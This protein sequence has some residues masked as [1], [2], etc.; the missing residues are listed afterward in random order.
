MD[1]ETIAAIAFMIFG[2]AVFT[3]GMND[4]HRYDQER[5]D[6]ILNNAREFGFED[7]KLRKKGIIHRP[8]K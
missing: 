6:R 7:S 5:H 4:I 8:R 1:G 3:R 2:I